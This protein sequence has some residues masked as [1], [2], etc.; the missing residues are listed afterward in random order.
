M[1]S[2][3]LCISLLVIITSVAKASL[4]WTALQK[5]FQRKYSLIHAFLGIFKRRIYKKT[6]TNSSLAYIN[7]PF[8]HNL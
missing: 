5:Y 8:K 2:L 3:D 1:F 7:S 6:S 4:L